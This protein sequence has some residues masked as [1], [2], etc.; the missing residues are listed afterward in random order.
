MISH[1]NGS[2]GEWDKA[3]WENIQD[4]ADVIGVRPNSLI[5]WYNRDAGWPCGDIMRPAQ[6]KSGRS[7]DDYS[8]YWLPPGSLDKLAGVYPKRATSTYRGLESRRKI[9]AA[10]EDPRARLAMLE[11]EMGDI[12]KLLDIV[13]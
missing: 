6:K 11:N 4:L 1:S 3:G 12:K 8:N 10:E 5:R 13:D 9:R 2:A 7:V